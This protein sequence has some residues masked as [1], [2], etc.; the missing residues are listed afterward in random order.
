MVCGFVKIGHSVASSDDAKCF[1]EILIKKG[2][3]NDNV[4]FERFSD[5]ISFA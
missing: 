1:D 3:N 2:H 5:D 4:F